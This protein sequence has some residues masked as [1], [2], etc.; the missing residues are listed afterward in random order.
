MFGLLGLIVVTLFLVVI[1]SI[2]RASELSSVLKGDE[3][4]YLRTSALMARLMMLTLILGFIGLVY[5][6]YKFVPLML[7]DAASAHGIKTDGLFNTTLAFTGIVLV[8]THIALFWFTFKYRE[9]KDRKAYFYPHNNQLEVIWTVIPAIVM[10]ILVVMGLRTW[11]E[12]F[13]GVEN[14][15]EDKLEVE[16]IAKQFGWTVRYPGGDGEFGMRSYDPELVSPTNEW[17]IDW[18]NDETSHDDIISSKIY[19]IKDKPVLFRLGALDVLHSFYLPHFRVK[20]DCVPG[21]PTYFYMTPTKTTEAMREELSQIPV[22]QTLTEEGKPRWQEFNY[23]LACAELCG[24]SHYAMRYEVI[25]VDSQEEY[26]ALLAEETV[27]YESV[28]LASMETD[29][30]VEEVM[31][32]EVIMEE[33]AED[34]EG[35]EHMEGEEAHEEEVEEVVAINN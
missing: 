7:P 31:E 14:M 29:E 24:K 5:S 18:A 32:E 10:T 9:Q 21:I 23:E 28:I 19:L 34:H 25:V 6:V 16:V 12:I 33:G 2:A 27:Y 20:M 30:E 17:G 26:D 4:S 13:P 15:A 35:E 3:N 1:L 11:F 8:L 22:W